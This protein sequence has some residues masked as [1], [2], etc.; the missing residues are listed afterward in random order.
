LSESAD[1]VAA[2]PADAPARRTAGVLLHPTSLPGPLPAGDL[3]PSAHAFLD[4]L[5]EAGL[6]LWQVLPLGPTG[7]GDSPYT[8]LSAFAGNPL[9]VSPERL[10]E[11]GL[12]EAREIEPFHVA[13]SSRADLAAAR[14][15]RE[16]LLVAAWERFSRRPPEHLA[17]AWRD[18]REDLANAAW[19]DDWTLF[20]A[21]KAERSGRPW[22]DWEES[23]RR[24]RRDDLERSRRRL[25]PA[26]ERLA[27]EQF[28]FFRQWRALRE[29][30]E[31]RG[32]E[33]IGDVPIYVAADSADVWAHRELFEVSREGRLRAVAG[34]PPDYFS[35]TGQRWGNPLFRW[36]RLAERGYDWWV[37]RVRHQ[38]TTTHRVRLDHFRGFVAYWRIPAGAATAESGRWATGPGRPLFDALRAAL[39][40]LPLIAEDLGQID[41]PVH[42]LRRA[43]GLPGMR[44]LQFGF[45]EPDSLH[46]PHRHTPDGVVY[47]GTHDNDTCRGWFDAAGEEVR[48]RT[49]VYLGTS[50]DNVPEAMVR[51]AFASPA[52]NAVI[53]LQDL[54]GLGSDARM[55]TP[56]RESSNWAFRILPELVPAE[57]PGRLRELAA[58]TARSAPEPR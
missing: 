3:G 14:R 12:L 51:A 20:A 2:A 47:T 45:D 56:G 41:A 19:L 48:R 36:R 23:L 49:L 18:F 43:L 9:L 35:A 28:L 55:N 38:L 54:L 30:A 42:E 40:G 21:L 25:E 37:E 27:F 57:L 32:I 17:T 5:R 53:P 24:R 1:A 29:A 58:A 46:A 15:C 10:V 31:A 26:I 4:W 52:A 6:A 8:A 50:P 7:Y 33:L 39:G 22:T 13:A 44:V 34:V 11:D 16:R